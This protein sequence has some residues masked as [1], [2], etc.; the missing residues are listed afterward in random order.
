MMLTQ[1]NMKL[2][3][4]AEAVGYTNVQYFSTIF[5]EKKD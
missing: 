1:T 4:I 5:K 3:D 2:Y